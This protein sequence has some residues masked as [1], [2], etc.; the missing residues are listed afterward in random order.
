MHS[1]H[2]DG[3]TRKCLGHKYGGENAKRNL[4]EI[5]EMLIKHEK[6]NVNIKFNNKDYS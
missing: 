3:S 1:Y 6:T 5:F 2:T 4:I